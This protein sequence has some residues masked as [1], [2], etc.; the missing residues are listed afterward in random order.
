MQERAYIAQ[1]YDYTRAK[2][3]EEDLRFLPEEYE[4]YELLDEED[5]LSSPSDEGG[6]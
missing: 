4:E 3:A 6:M 5:L 1:A 2:D